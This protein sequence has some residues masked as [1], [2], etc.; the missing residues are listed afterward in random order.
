MTLED[1]VRLMGSLS[2]VSLLSDLPLARRVANLQAQHQVENPLIPLKSQVLP[3]DGLHGQ[4][5]ARPV[6]AMLELARATSLNDDP[7]ISSFARR[8][9]ILRHLGIFSRDPLGRLHLDGEALRYIGPNQRRV[10]SEDLGVG[11]AILAAKRWCRTRNGGSFPI[12][13]TDVDKALHRGSVPGLTRNGPRQPDYVLSYPTPRQP[14]RTTYELVEAKGSVNRHTAKKQLGRAVTQLAGLTLNGRTLTGVASSTVSNDSELVILSVDPEK[15]P[16]TWRAT[17][18]T[19]NRLRSVRPQLRSTGEVTDV[20]EDEFLAAS[21]DT[22]N[23]SLAQYAG[24]RGSA[25]RWLPEHGADR[26]HQDDVTTS[27]VYEAGTFVGVES[28]ITFPGSH[29][30]L[31]VFQGVDQDVAATLRESDP[32]AVVQAQA[33]AAMRSS[34]FDQARSTEPVSGDGAAALATSSDGSL[35]EISLF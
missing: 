9:S 17:E 5:E 35:L 14:G 12:T 31:R 30:H 24:L 16:L 13:I 28:L 15:P 20:D 26:P 10:L 2:T 6:A 8:W 11:F 22:S 34:D 19:L 25:T 4:F 18:E 33:A 23:A 29:K 1:A 3:A 27:R 21:T 7:D 32:Q